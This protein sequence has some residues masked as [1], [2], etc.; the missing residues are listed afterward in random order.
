[1]KRKRHKPIPFDEFCFEDSGYESV[2]GDY[3]KA[4]TLYAAAKEQKCKPY[5]LPIEHLDLSG[6]PWRCGNFDAIVYH[7]KR[8]LGTDLKHP[9]LVGPLGNIMDGWHRIGKAMMDGKACIKAIRLD[10]LPDPDEKK[11]T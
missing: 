5:W 8:M 3:W 7:A 1:M 10:G 2:T 6:M 4:T 11:E 9:I